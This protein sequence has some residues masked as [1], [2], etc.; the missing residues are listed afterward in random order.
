MRGYQSKYVVCPFYHQ[1]SGLRIQCEGFCKSC[2]LQITFE[3]KE[4]MLCHRKNFCESFERHSKCPLFPVISR[5]YEK[6][7]KNK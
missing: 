1:E 5:Q 3:N 6:V 2:S 4:D 7:K